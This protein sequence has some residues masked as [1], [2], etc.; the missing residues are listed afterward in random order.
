[1]IVDYVSSKFECLWRAKLPLISVMPTINDDLMKNVDFPTLMMSSE[2]PHY[3]AK[4]VNLQ[5]LNVFEVIPGV[6][7]V[8]IT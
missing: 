7:D 3:S 4:I 8:A 1:M 5:L 6:K 2:G